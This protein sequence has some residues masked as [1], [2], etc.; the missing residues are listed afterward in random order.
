M[1]TTYNDAYFWRPASSTDA[2][3]VNTT[4]YVYTNANTGVLASVESKMTFNSGNSIT[5]GLSTFDNLGRPLYRQQQEGAGAIN[6]DTTQAIYD[7]AGRPYQSTMPCV[8]SSK[9]GCPTAAKRRTIMTEWVESS[10][11]RM[12][13]VDT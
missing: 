11:R 8:A 7:V 3:Q 4:N 12:A 1:T 13:E 2:T 10:K 9:Q 5:E 6:Y